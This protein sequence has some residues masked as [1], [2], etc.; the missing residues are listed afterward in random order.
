MVYRG[1]M[2]FGFR[3]KCDEGVAMEGSAM[4]Y[5][6]GRSW[7]GTVSS[8]LGKC[9]FISFMCIIYNFSVPPSAPELSILISGY[10]AE[11]FIVPGY[12]ILVSCQTNSG[13]PVP[14]VDI[15]LNGKLV[16]SNGTFVFEATT[17]D[18][19]DIKCVAHNKAGRSETKCSVKVTK[20]TILG[21]EE[22]K[23]GE[24]V[25]LTCNVSGATQTP[26]V[27][28]IAE[29]DGSE[30][31]EAYVINEEVEEESGDATVNIKIDSDTGSRY[32]GFSVSI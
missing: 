16:T 20:A 14:E 3:Y 9:Q 28:W 21:P 17:E 25:E 26:S 23:Q 31:I 10:P 30:D 8:C 2:C 19:V 11:T 24:T 4:V 5:C 29:V 15:F 1:Y 22:A 12:P 32:S 18:D 6:D 7:N 27:S 13:N